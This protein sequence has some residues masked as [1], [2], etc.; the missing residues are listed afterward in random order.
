[1]FLA[2]IFGTFFNSTNQ[3]V[4]AGAKVQRLAG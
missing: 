3:S 1:M 2:Y 4:N